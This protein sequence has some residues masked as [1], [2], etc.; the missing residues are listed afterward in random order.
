MNII[1]KIKMKTYAD[2]KEILFLN[3]PVSD[4]SRDVIGVDAYVDKLNAAIDEGA[5]MI[6][7]TAPFGAGKTSVIE[8]LEKKRKKKRFEKIVK[9]SMWSQFHGDNKK[10]STNDLHRSFLYQLISQI[11]LKRADYI[12]RR[13]SPNYGLFKLNVNSRG[14]WLCLFLAALLLVICWVVHSLTQGIGE[15]IQFLEGKE[16]G[17]IVICGLLG[18]SLMLYILTKAEI[19]F[20]SHKSAELKREIESEEIMELYRKEILKKPNL[21][22]IRCKYIAVIEDLDRTADAEAVV[23]FL[24]ELRKYYIPQSKTNKYKNKVTF[25]VNVN[26]E[27]LLW[28]I[29]EKQRKEY[30]SNTDDNLINDEKDIIKESLYAKLFDYTLNLQTINVDNY[31]VVLEGLL[32]ENNHIIE[33]LE[34]KDYKTIPG[35]KWIIRERRLGIREI[36]E[37]LNIAFSL[38]ESLIQKFPEKKANI[39]FEKCAVVAYL[40]TAFE[41]DFYGTSD[42]AFQ[43]LV[44][45]HLKESLSLEE[46]NRELPNTSGAYVETV[47]ELIEA[48]LIDSSY[49]TYFYNYPKGSYLYSVEESQVI[50]AILYK[51]RV[52]NLEETAR[53]VSM[54]KVETIERAFQTLEQLGLSLPYTVFESETLY[55]IAL[56]KYENKVLLYFDN[57]EYTS[58]ELKKNLQFFEKILK[59]DSDRK[60]YS[61]EKAV[62]FCSNWEKHF[63]ET[64]IL[65]LRQMLCVEFASEIQWYKSLFNGVHAI[66]RNEEIDAISVRDALMITNIESEELSIDTV[67]C[68]FEHYLKGNDNTVEKEMENFLQKVGALFESFEMALLY[69]DFMKHVNRIIPDF[70]DRVYKQLNSYAN[71]TEE[72]KIIFTKYQELINQ[73]SAILSEKTVENICNLQQYEGY[74]SEVSKRV[75]EQGWLTDYVILQKTQGGYISFEQEEIRQALQDDKEWLLERKTDFADI[76]LLLVQQK[77]NTLSQYLFMFDKN[78]PVL[79][80]GELKWIEDKKNGDELFMKLLPAELVTEEIGNMVCNFFNRKNQSNN[81]SYAILKYI[82]QFSSNVAQ[83]CF[84]RLDFDKIKYQGLASERKDNIKKWFFDSLELEK[85]REKIHFMKATKYLDPAWE[86]EL[87]EALKED[88]D[89]Q[90]EYISCVNAVGKIQKGTINILCELGTLY[91]MSEQVNEKYL[92]LKKYEEY[93]VSKTLKKKQ[94]DMEE[95]E[96]KQK[97]WPV[98]IEIFSSTAG[99]SQT[100][101]YMSKNKEFVTQVMR[102][103]L[104]KGWDAEARQLLN[105]VYQDKDSIEDVI[106]YGE[107][108]ALKYYSSMEGFWD[109]EAATAFISVLERMVVLLASDEL[110]QHTHD[111][112]INGRLKAKYT[113]LRK[114]NG[115]GK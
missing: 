105:G 8:L 74:D 38:Y 44:N 107:E 58:E 61:F 3:T 10:G 78:C 6:A 68:I 18:I 35:M 77:E 88:M 21:L 45:L 47:K 15:Y 89:L 50:N 13:L 76:R 40:I 31:D 72:F 23:K 92:E 27:S 99:Y 112:L 85:E 7:I 98:Y 20:S 19:V 24:K 84:Y 4:I 29:V 71:S 1:R 82:S 79:T 55:C 12:N 43:N 32:K 49:R 100:R 67:Q 91:P 17:V 70:E 95:G 2:K 33:L 26:P 69:L 56:E 62:I 41:K 16:D 110:Y 53:K 103:K 96:L 64:E 93:V 108:F 22:R 73:N 81:I 37:R 102:E 111:K 65:R 86:I 83:M 30:Q 51:E 14:Y 113:N 36:K 54:M 42:R 59:Y 114:K 109:E 57:L 75:R 48:K 66:I 97:L 9:I 52:D 94:F 5:Q 87:L 39:A 28:D 63:N 104:Y 46:C 90:K 11:N 80:L 34:E 115:Y 101:K 25:I 106:S 60:I